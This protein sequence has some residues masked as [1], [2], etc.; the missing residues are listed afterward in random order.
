MVTIAQ[1]PARCN[2]KL[3]VPVTLFSLLPSKLRKS[4]PTV[5]RR[6]Y[7]RASSGIFQWRVPRQYF[8]QLGTME[9]YGM[10]FNIPSHV[11]G[12]LKCVYGDDWKI[13]KRK[14]TESDEKRRIDNGALKV[15]NR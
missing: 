5:M 3:L 14:M 12:Y 1:G 15:I 4:L 11:E 8:E 2:R 10:T 7:C 9:F 6:M 13:P